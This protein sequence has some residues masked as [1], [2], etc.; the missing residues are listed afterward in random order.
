MQDMSK[1]TKDDLWVWKTLFNRQ[2]ENIPGKASKSYIDALEHMSPV[3][4][5]D[6]IPD[7]E[8]IN[9]WFKTETQWELQVVPGL[10]PVEEFFKLLADRKFCSST[11]LRSKDSLDYLEEPDVFHDIFG[12]VPLLS[13]PVFSEFL[14][15]FGKLGCQFLEDSEKLIQLQRLYWFTIEFG[16]IREQGNIQSYGAGILSSSG[17]TN[18]IHERKANFIEYSIQAIIEKEFRTDIMQKDYYVVSSFEVLFESLKTLTDVWNTETI[19]V[20]ES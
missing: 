20:K 19:L 14:H 5:A 3:L 2:K 4:N 13:D 18:Q 11:W 8:K 6:E 10:I 15:E 9:L 1:Y 16:V 7:F 12:H 17:E